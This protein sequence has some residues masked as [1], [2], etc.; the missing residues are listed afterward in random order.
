MEWQ[1]P[2][3]MAEYLGETELCDTDNAEITKKA[4]EIVK[5]AKTPK[6][7]A[8]G[9]F[10]FVRDHILFGMDNCDVRASDT[11]KKRMGHCITKTT[12]QVA[13]LRAAGIP[14]RYHQVVL[15]KDCLKGII[16]PLLHG[17]LPD[18]IWFHPWCEC[19]LSEKWVSCDSLFDRALYDAITRKGII[20]KEQIP[21]IDWDGENDLNTMNAWMLEDTGTFHS[22]DD[23]FRQA[24]KEVLPP[25]IITRILFGF[26]NRYTDRLRKH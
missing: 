3:G 20:S 8:L 10:S 1:P 16:S 11:L 22:L 17:R 26:S 4:E 13:L 2:K 19:Y 12:L 21:T 6:E 14:A 23:V 18:K 5:D 9:I 15:R 7:A 25:K 24:Q